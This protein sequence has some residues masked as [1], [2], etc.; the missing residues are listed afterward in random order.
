MLERMEGSEAKE[1]VNARFEAWLVIERNNQQRY[2]EENVSDVNRERERLNALPKAE[3]DEFNQ[4]RIKAGKKPVSWPL[5]PLT[6]PVW[7]D[8]MLSASRVEIARKVCKLTREEK[9][10]LSIEFGSKSSAMSSEDFQDVQHA[11]VA[12]ENGEEK[13]EWQARIEAARQ[14]ALEIIAKRKVAADADSMELSFA[15]C[16]RSFGPEGG[17]FHGGSEWRPELWDKLTAKQREPL[18]QQWERAERLLPV[19]YEYARQSVTLLQL[20]VMHETIKQEMPEK[21]RIPKRISSKPRLGGCAMHPLE[22]TTRRKI[23][24]LHARIGGY[25]EAVIQSLG[26]FLV[27]DLPYPL[28]PLQQRKWAASFAISCNESHYYTGPMLTDAGPVLDPWVIGQVVRDRVRL[29]KIEEATKTAKIEYRVIIA[30]EEHGKTIGHED[31]INFDK[32]LHATTSDQE[33]MNTRTKQRGHFRAL[34]NEGGEVLALKVVWKD[35]RDSELAEAFLQLLKRLRPRKSKKG[36]YYRAMPEAEWPERP[37]K[38]KQGSKWQAEAMAAL[39]ALI[40]L[41]GKQSAKNALHAAQAEGKRL[42]RELKK[43]GWTAQEQAAIEAGIQEALAIETETGKKTK[44]QPLSGA[45]L[46][47]IT[48]CFKKIVGDDESPWWKKLSAKSI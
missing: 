8:S 22:F 45:K 32:A 38:Q 23:K 43:G 13:R 14:T 12:W 25:A 11:L 17:G 36:D 46:A 27:E 7:K 48:A 21:M 34:D 2:I 15:D 47:R 35:T 3:Q 30:K 39:N 31:V 41:Q 9:K 44:A 5:K 20:A 4:E 26:K 24:E 10:V 40:D 42:K 37:A 1:I 33:V 29:A 16:F 19:Y 6:A 18:R 28:I